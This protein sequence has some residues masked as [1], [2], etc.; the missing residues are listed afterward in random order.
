[1]MLRFIKSWP[2][3]MVVLAATGS[4]NAGFQVQFTDVGAGISTGPIA[5][6]NG[7]TIGVTVGNFTISG[8]TTITNNPGDATSAWISINN[9]AVTNTSG[10]TDT[11]IAMESA[12]DF[13][14]PT[15]PSLFLQSTAD[16]LVAS[17]LLLGDSVSTPSHF[18]SYVNGNDTLF[19]TVGAVASPV[20]S[21]TAT[22]SGFGFGQLVPVSS[23][24]FALGGNYSITNV[25]YY[26]LT[27]GTRVTGTL[28]YSAVIVPEPA[29]MVMA[30][31]GSCIVL[32]G[33]VVRRR[34][35]A[36]FAV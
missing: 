26:T 4:A 2:A 28:G 3:L 23:N 9:A 22:G 20:I 1:M 35:H 36:S 5:V 10:S 32:F 31:I 17:G 25:G 18:T 33:S 30:G 8:V 11:L 7:G 19:S 24:G 15:G 6:T 29:S 12:N 21:F 14:A 13:T 34:R 16:G 27:P